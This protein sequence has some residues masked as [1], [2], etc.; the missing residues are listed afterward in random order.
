LAG[1]LVLANGQSGAGHS[2][3]HFPSYY[4]DEIRIDVVGPEA[5][6]KGL[7]DA[8]VHAYVGAAPKFSGPVPARV[9]SVKSLGS[10]LVLSFD[11]ASTRFNRPRRAAPPPAASCSSC[12]AAMTPAL[13]F[14]PTP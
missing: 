4:P 14:I 12:A 8:T 1:A 11:A 3:G 5:A 10:L 6:A 9:K 7:A 13:F 2:V